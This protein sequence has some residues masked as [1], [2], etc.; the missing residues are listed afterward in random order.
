MIHSKYHRYVFAFFMSL[1]MSCIMSLVI[2]IFNVGMVGNILRIWIESSALSF[3]IAFPTIVVISPTV[4]R[5]VSLA[6]H[7]PEDG[8]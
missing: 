5:L 2:S 1:L 4:N 3:V 6:L 8:S 7:E